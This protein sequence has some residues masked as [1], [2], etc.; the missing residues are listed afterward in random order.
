MDQ[1][2][3]GRIQKMI[4]CSVCKEFL[5]LSMKPVQRKKRKVFVD[6]NRKHLIEHGITMLCKETKIKDIE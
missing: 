4:S 3:L 5:A 6:V 2:K 1:Q